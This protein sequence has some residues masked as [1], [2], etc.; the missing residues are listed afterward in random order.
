MFGFY[1]RY[2]VFQEPGRLLVFQ[3]GLK[4]LSRSSDMEGEEFLR[5]FMWKSSGPTAADFVCR[6]L[7]NGYATII[8][9]L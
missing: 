4:I 2:D 1:N 7:F 6:I 9:V 5:S 8:G 3:I